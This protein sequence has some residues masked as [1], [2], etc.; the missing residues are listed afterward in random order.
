ML[1]R[2]KRIDTPGDPRG[3]PGP[4]AQDP[5]PRAR[6]KVSATPTRTLARTLAALDLDG[7]AEPS[8][9]PAE[10]ARVELESCWRP[11][12]PHYARSYARSR[13]APAAVAHANWGALA[14]GKRD[15]SKV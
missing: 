7:L 11:G 10:V 9:G 8:A 4:K 12:E 15:R 3:A 13:E 1:R 6:F 14:V 2:R 5:V